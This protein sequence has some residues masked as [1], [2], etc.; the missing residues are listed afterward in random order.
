MA[1]KGSG[2]RQALLGDPDVRRWY[3]NT[4]RG[5]LTT[6]DNYLRMLGI[7]LEG[8]ALSPKEF[9]ALEPKRRD[10]I[11]ADY[12]E[13]MLR[14]GKAGS[15]A[16]V[17]KKAVA[18]W[19]DWNGLKFT[20]R[21]K[22]PGAHK[23]PSLVDAHIPTQEELR[24]VLRM[25]DV[26]AKAVIGL[27][28]FSG[29]REQVLGTYKGDEGLRLKSFPEL[30]V[31]ETLRFA[32]VPTRVE[33]PE[34][35][36]KTGRPYF[37]FLGPEGCEY[38]LG[39]LRKRQGQGETLTSDSSVIRPERAKK[40]FIR[41]LNIAD[42]IRGPMR[43]AGLKEP[44]YIWRSFFDS[45]AMMAESKGFIR[46][47]RQFFM[48]HSGD[49]EHVYALHKTV[50]PDTIEDMR[51]AYAKALPLLESE[52]RVSAEDPRRDVLEVLLAVVGYSE[53]DIEAMDFDNMTKEEVARLIEGAPRQ[54]L[55]NDGSGPRQ[56]ILGMED[57]PDA[58]Q[59]GWTFKA[60]LPDGRVVV[61][62][63]EEAWHTSPA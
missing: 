3:E 53:T 44:P 29:L 45:R 40:D 10:D 33:I 8:T 60:S 16:A 57:L 19:L 12:I 50:P 32:Q 43:R 31:Q 18:S 54:I 9:V 59:E 36:S 26:R 6:A 27:M 23:R 62:T 25:A 49:I 51:E 14:A 55:A 37:S 56:R 46:D 15:Y 39:Y 5:A 48:G 47:Y 24:K 52:P 7:F 61:E 42:I 28:A 34:F 63:P 35:L 22:V 30:E 13:G 4:A 11:L 38:L 2:K 20:R 21:I 1:R 58:L 17:I 41:T